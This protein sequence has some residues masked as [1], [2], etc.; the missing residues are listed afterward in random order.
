[1]SKGQNA[2]DAM[3]LGVL[4]AKH[5]AK[6]DVA[7]NPWDHS[8]RPLPWAAEWEEK[9]ADS[10][11]LAQQMVANTAGP[12]AV[13]VGWKP[14]GDRKTKQWQGAFAA[15]VEKAISSSGPPV[16][17]GA[18]GNVP[19]NFSARAA[20]DATETDGWRPDNGTRGKLGVQD[21]KPPFPGQVFPKGWPGVVVPGSD[22]G[23]Y[24]DLFLPGGGALV[25]PHWGG[26]GELGTLVY[27]VKNGDE[28][29]KDRKANLQT[30]T[31]VYRRPNT[32][33]GP[34][35]GDVSGYS[36]AWQIGLARDGWGGRGTVADAPN[37]AGPAPGGI[38]TSTVQGSPQQLASVSARLSSFLEVGHA[39]DK[40]R[41]GTNEDGEH[42]NAAHLAGRTTFF[43]LDST[44][45][46]PLEFSD[47]PYPK[48]KPLAGVEV[49]VYLSYDQASK[50]GFLCGEKDGL[51]RWWTRS[52]IVPPPPPPPP[53]GDGPGYPGGGG[54]TW[55]WPTG[56]GK[57]SSGGGGGVLGG[58]SKDGEGDPFGPQTPYDPLNPDGP[59]PWTLDPYDPNNPANP[60]DPQNPYRP[61]L[62]ETIEQDPVRGGVV[63]IQS[64]GGVV[65]ESTP[66]DRDA[67][68][69]WVQQR[70]QQLTTPQGGEGDDARHREACLGYAQSVNEL[71]V[72]ALLARPQSAHPG[73][74][75]YRNA[76]SWGGTDAARLVN[77]TPVAGRLEA[78][79]LQS[80]TG[81]GPFTKTPGRGRY[82]GGTVDGGF[83]LLP[84]EVG[85]EQIYD[86]TVPETR[87]RTVI[88]AC[89]SAVAYGCID[90]RTGHVPNGFETL[91]VGD[92][93]TTYHTSST[94]E[95]ETSTPAMVLNNATQTV[96]VYGTELGA[97]PFPY[98]GDGSDGAAAF[99]G[100]TTVAGAS[101]S[102]SIY[103]LTRNTNY[104]SATVSAGV[105]VKPVGFFFQGTGTLLNLGKIERNG[106]DA[107]S[108]AGGS[109]PG[110]TQ[111]IGA[112]GATGRTTS[113][114]GVGGSA[115]TA[116]LG[117][118]GGNSGSTSG[119]SAGTG[120]LASSS[121]PA[122]TTQPPYTT[123]TAV[124]NNGRMATLTAAIDPSGGGSGASG[125]FEVG[126][127]GR[128]GS[129]GASAGNIQ[130]CFKT[131][132]TAGGTIEAKGGNAFDAAGTGDMGGGGGGG[133][134]CIR[135][136]ARTYVGWTVGSTVL[137]TKGL[138]SNGIGAGTAGVD[139]TDGQV[140]AFTA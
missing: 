91:L 77:E 116:A 108:T 86:G 110:G 128:S 130:I 124:L 51:H 24:Q 61:P 43:F 64:Q 133:G 106:G 79:G 80:S 39:V 139:G 13:G 29:D 4:I 59:Q 134:G 140:F 48:T 54:P 68:G 20:F 60:F 135:A 114:N 84:P 66:M 131:I 22:L 111:G 119:G 45:D 35:F 50:H 89:Y 132:N 15:L 27:D 120:G 94:G 30:L 99:D 126:A 3:T 129:G 96:S 63:L 52:A 112:A 37:L 32:C 85:V 103:T 10:G 93:L 28:I 78:V 76:T 73:N 97:A 31:R 101:R 16:T 47:A 57:G 9:V 26:R 88:A 122:T 107:T 72:P 25:A 12:F 102:G 42:M 115:F 56:P 33:A 6:A 18:G 49:P 100:S 121:R 58:G 104:T 113:G 53:P 98:G 17:Q 127:V 5:V 14:E 67:Y 123:I 38:M 137:V 8:S 69:A 92:T 81:W 46:A 55:G 62:V 11:L 36:L 95:R 2:A 44:R 82:C 83:M 71:S 7:G 125:A 90:P 1:M 87:S 23:T 40:H 74:K 109:A 117:G 34:L 105:T 21:V 138:K 41:L 70:A 118:D 136:V 19:G 75:D 65:V